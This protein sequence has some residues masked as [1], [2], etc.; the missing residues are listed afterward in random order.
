MAEPPPLHRQRL[1]H[2]RL[3]HERPAASPVTWRTPLRLALLVVAPLAGAFVFG[4]AAVASIG[5]NIEPG[6]FAF[7]VAL[8]LLAFASSLVTGR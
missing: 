7:G 4:A 3:H 2:E 8:V 5:G 6:R 1:H